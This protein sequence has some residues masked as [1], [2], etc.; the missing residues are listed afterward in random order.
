[1]FNRIL[2]VCTANICRSPI[3]EALLK[4]SLPDHVIASAGTRVASSH[5]INANAHHLSQQVSA[6]RGFDLSDHAA[7]Q[8]S[9][10]L[11]SEFDLILVMSHDH[12]D[13]VAQLLPG[14][15]SKTML[16]GQWIGQGDIDDPIHQPKEAF[17]SLFRTLVRAT[18][19][20]VQKLT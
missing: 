6:E 4:A 10:E 3:A 8:L 18:D 20:W 7:K 1:M 17:D 16:L 5:L 13:E 14:S 11:C 9:P 15:R 12:I 19:A 2:V